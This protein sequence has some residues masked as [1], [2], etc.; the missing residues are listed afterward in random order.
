ML[1]VPTVERVSGEIEQ[2]RSNGSQR[3]YAETGHSIGH[4]PAVEIF[5]AACPNSAP[6][7]TTRLL[8]GGRISGSSDS[9]NS[10]VQAYLDGRLPEE[11][12]AEQPTLRLSQ[13]Y[14][15]IAFYLDQKETDDHRPEDRV[16]QR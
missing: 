1:H 4:S 11:I 9:I 13:V 8:L 3:L 10:V 12:H 6:V 2:R 15:L 7:D 14:A 5:A 16:A